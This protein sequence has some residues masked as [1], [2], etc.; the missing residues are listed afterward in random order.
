MLQL[1]SPQGEVMNEENIY[2]LLLLFHTF[3]A[4]TK[5]RMLQNL[6]QL[7]TE[8]VQLVRF[9]SAKLL[10]S[11]IVLIIDCIFWCSSS[12]AFVNCGRYSSPFRFN[13]R[14]I[15]QSTGS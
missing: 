9:P 12:C 2:I 13:S 1:Q 7:F 14:I 8:S 10:L 11:R 6:L 15:Q 4:D 5:T 3:K